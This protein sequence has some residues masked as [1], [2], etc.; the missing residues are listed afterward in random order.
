MLRKYIIFILEIL[1]SI[2][3][4]IN[5]NRL[6]LGSHQLI[7][8]KY[9]ALETWYPKHTGFLRLNQVS[10]CDWEIMLPNLPILD[11]SFI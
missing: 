7:Y 3:R 4:Y 5:I 6:I 8:E 10:N 11:Y 2:N 1:V 9:E